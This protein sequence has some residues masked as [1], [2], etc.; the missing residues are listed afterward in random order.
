[1]CPTDSVNEL[2]QA[3][4]EHIRDVAQRLAVEFTEI[5]SEDA[6]MQ[7][8]SELATLGQG[9]RLNKTGPLFCPTDSVNELYQATAEHIRD[10][11]QRLAVE[12]TEIT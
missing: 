9:A 6:L 10:V 8:R 12:F 1:F 4:A 5:T 11:A 7:N 3:T 2:Y